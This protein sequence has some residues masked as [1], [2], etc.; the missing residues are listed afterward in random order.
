MNSFLVIAGLL[1]LVLVLAILLMLQVHQKREYL[2]FIR[3]I[4]TA[5]G[6]PFHGKPS[7]VSFMEQLRKLNTYKTTPEAQNETVSMSEYIARESENYY[8]F[9]HA[10]FQIETVNSILQEGFK[11]EDSLYK[12][13]HL[14]SADPVDIKYK[15]H[16]V[17]Q[18]GNFIVLLCIPR[19]LHDFTVL[20]I[21]SCRLNLQAESILSRPI[22]DGE[23]KYLLPPQFVRSFI[24]LIT[25]EQTENDHFMHGYSFDSWKKI[26]TEKIQ[27][28]CKKH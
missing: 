4:Y 23:M 26:V 25:N 19:E 6:L 8:T 5:T 2:D 11:F 3:N 27:Y 28:E 15:V 21:S 20:Q 1:V 16:L 12:T 9:L 24:N 18:H 17:R 7:L 14:V 22:R 10:T 13:T